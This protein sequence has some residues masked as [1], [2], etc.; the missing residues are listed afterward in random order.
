MTKPVPFVPAT[1]VQQRPSTS[2]SEFGMLTM[3][4][5]IYIGLCFKNDTGRPEKLFE[6]YAKMATEVGV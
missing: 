1:Y 2:S 6:M 3:Q 5:S 4:E